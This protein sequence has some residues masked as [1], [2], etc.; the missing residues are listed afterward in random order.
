M[1]AAPVSWP[2]RPIRLIVPFGAGGPDTTARILGQQLS[3]QLGQPIIVDNR[4]GAN[5][6]IGADAVAKAAPDGYTLMLT[7]ASFAVNP[8][9]Y[10]KLPYDSKRD[11]VDIAQVAAGEGLILAVYPGV[12][13]RTLAEFL[14][15][16]R[17]PNSKI[18]YGSPGIGNTL[19]LA[20]ERFNM[21]AGTKMLHVP[22]KGGGPAAAALLGGEIQAMLMTAPTA[23][24][25]IRAG[26]LRALAFTG[27]ARAS[28]LPDVPTLKEAGVPDFDVDAGWHGL[29]APA[30]TPPAI[31]Q[32][33]RQ[34]VTK[35]LQTPEMAQAIKETGL[36]PSTLP[37]DAFTKL[38][39]ADIAKYTELVRIARV[40]PE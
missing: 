21:R 19:H 33:L 36:I 1:R 35:A 16:A 14:A 22:Y 32:R 3:K 7:S 18:A 27:D 15:L 40:E 26:K 28:Y 12:P 20:G 2:D 11:F 23:L 17:D 13:A 5:G 34:E 6:I 39:D 25:Q 10:K 24:P 37:P 9:I 8:S 38:V 30:H 31:V 29:F 4:A